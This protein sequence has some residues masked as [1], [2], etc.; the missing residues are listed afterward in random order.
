M[1][2]I[3]IKKDVDI[4]KLSNAKYLDNLAF[5][6]WLKGYYELNGG[7]YQY[8]HEKGNKSSRYSLCQTSPSFSQKSLEKQQEKSFNELEKVKRILHV[9]EVKIGMMMEILKSTEV[10]NSKVDLLKEIITLSF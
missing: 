1:N 2:K 10:P 4:E 8:S 7:N 6:Q 3:G 9:N 5:V